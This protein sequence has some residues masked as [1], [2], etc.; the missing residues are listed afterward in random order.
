MQ[1]IFDSLVAAFRHM[2]SPTGHL[3]LGEAF[4]A[5]RG[6]CGFVQL[7]LQKPARYGIKLQCLCNAK[8]K[9]CNVEV[10]SGKQPDGSLQLPN[11]PH[12]ITLQ[13]TAPIVGMS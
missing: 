9:Y 13:L 3:T 6:R 2:C 4:E 12:D 5:F 8:T 1:N 7:M 10:Y 11:R